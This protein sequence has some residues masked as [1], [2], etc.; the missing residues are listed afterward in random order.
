M[1]ARWFSRSPRR[2]PSHQG[3]RPGRLMNCRRRRSPARSRQPKELASAAKAANITL[4]VAPAP[5][6]LLADTA[7][8]VQNVCRVRRQ[9]VVALRLPPPVR[10]IRLG[11]GTG[12]LRQ[13]SLSMVGLSSKATAARIRSLASAPRWRRFACGGEFRTTTTDAV[14]FTWLRPAFGRW[15]RPGRAGSVTKRTPTPG[16]YPELMLPWY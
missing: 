9:R 13:P 5:G 14:C 11:R 10:R 1:D 8:A 4:L 3:S 7:H 16:S 6:T 15:V 12:G 2:L